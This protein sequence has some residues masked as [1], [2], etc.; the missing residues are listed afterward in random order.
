MGLLDGGFEGGEDVAAFAFQN[1]VVFAVRFGE[2]ADVGDQTLV[3][4]VI[5]ELQ[6]GVVGDGLVETVAVVAVDF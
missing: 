2:A 5:I 4:A 6:T 1:F 3:G